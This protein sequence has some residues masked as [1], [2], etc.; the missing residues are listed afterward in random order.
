MRTYLIAAAPACFAYEASGAWLHC[1]TVTDLVS[2]DLGTNL[3][4]QVF[5]KTWNRPNTNGI[6]FETTP[7]DS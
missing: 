1:D 7:D 5:R 4:R 6:P 3:S 2:F